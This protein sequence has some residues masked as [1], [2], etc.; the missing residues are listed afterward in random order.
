MAAASFGEKRELA[1]TVAQFALQQICCPKPEDLLPHRR[2]D[3]IFEDIWQQGVARGEFRAD[4]DPMQ[5]HGVL[6]SVFVGAV[7]W[8]VG[9]ADG[10]VHPQALEFALPDIVRANMKVVFDGLRKT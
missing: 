3:Q 6:G 8:W 10:R 5:A 1:R 9:A 2:H 7:T 4:S